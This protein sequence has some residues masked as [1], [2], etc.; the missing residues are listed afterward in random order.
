MQS[1][2]ARFISSLLASLWLGLLAGAS[3]AQAQAVLQTVRVAMPDGVE[4]ATDVWTKFFDSTPYPVLLRRTP[5]GRAITQE[6]A[7]NLI[8]AGYMVVSQDVR[9]RGE[10]AGEFLPFFD[11]AV[12]GKATIEWVAAQ[13]WSN[14]RVGTYSASA[15][16]IVQY[17]AMADAPEGLRCAQVMVPTHDLYE[18]LFPGGAWRTDLGTNWLTSQGATA[19]IDVLK[20]HEARDEFWDRAT[21]STDEMADIDHPVFI[22]GGMFDIFATSEVRAFTELQTHVAAASRADIFLVMGPWTH[23]GTGSRRQGELL[24][25]ENAPYL[26]N[27]TDFVGYFDWCLRDAARPSLPALRYFITELT[28]NVAVDPTDNMP[29]IEAGG[30]W[31]TGESWPPAG[32]TNV[33]MFI[34]EDDALSGEAPSEST[35]QIALVIDPTDMAPSLGGGNLTSAAGPFDQAVIDAR[36]DVYVAQTA[37]VIEPVEI[38]G[39]VRARIWAASATTDIDVIVRAEVLTPGGKAVAFADGIRRGRFAGGFDEPRAMTPGEPVLFDIEVGPVAL[40]LM[41]G[42]A[43]RFAISSVSTPRYEPNPN[44]ADP[45]VSAQP[46]QATTLTLYRDAAHPSRFDIP[47]A[48]GTLPGTLEM[49]DAGALEMPDAGGSTIEPRDGGEVGT[50]DAGVTATDAAIVDAGS[51][52]PPVA[53]PS[54]RSATTPA[55]ECGCRAVGGAGNNRSPAAIA[56]LVWLALA[57]TRAWPRSARAWRRAQRLRR[58]RSGR[59]GRSR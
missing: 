25:P 30:E 4:L 9:G 19:V 27:V 36:P 43:L 52:L 29:V 57:L 8:A 37:A 56:A 41:E 45:L 17:M 48:F 59:G 44:S 38:I 35:A 5:Y 1:P 11:D 50:P 7:N 55:S 24:Y 21:L 18:G 16:G 53:T 32:A 20:T 34:Q 15:E 33:A 40:R 28:D 23:G 58:L 46:P 39:N 10:S 3:H 2:I 49:P 51:S 54:T 31:R 13:P 47:V 42:H 22:V 6:Q 26:D 14:G 12:D